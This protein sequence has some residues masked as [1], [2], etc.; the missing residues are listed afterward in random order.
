MNDVFT[1]LTDVQ[2]INELVNEAVQLKLKGRNAVLFSVLE[3]NTVP[4]LEVVRSLLL[5][6]FNNNNFEPVTPMDILYTFPD[7]PKVDNTFSEN[8]LH[9]I[10]ATNIFLT[11]MMH[12][13]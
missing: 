6:P 13:D 5:M 7:G 10:L 1:R 9:H 12:K 4:D 11:M 8:C 2:N 3:G